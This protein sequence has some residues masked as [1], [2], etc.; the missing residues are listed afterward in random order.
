MKPVK[1]FLSAVACAG[2]LLASPASMALDISHAP[3]PLILVD[4]TGTFGASFLSGN[5]S[6]TFS[7]KY[8]FSTLGLNFVDTLV[9]SIAHSSMVGLSVT[10]YDLYDST[11]TL[12]APG[13]MQSTGVVDLWTIATGGIPAGNYYVKVSGTIVSNGSASYAGNL[14]V[15]PVPEPGTYAMLLA[16]LGVVAVGARRR[17]APEPAFS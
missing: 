15:T 16:G 10:G 9:G 7:D 4:G 14:N 17:A 6:N 8:L 2:A 5:A 1:A 11:D 3:A 12:V 13:T